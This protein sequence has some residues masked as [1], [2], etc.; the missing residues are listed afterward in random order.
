MVSLSSFRPCQLLSRSLYDK[1]VS[2]STCSDVC[3]CILPQVCNGDTGHTE[4]VQF[5]ASVRPLLGA[6]RRQPLPPESG[7]PR[8]HGHFYPPLRVKYLDFQEVHSCA[9]KTT[10]ATNATQKQWSGNSQKLVC[11]RV[12]VRARALSTGRGW[13][14][15]WTSAEGER[16]GMRTFTHVSGQ[17]FGARSRG[18]AMTAFMITP[19]KTAAT[20]LS[21]QRRASF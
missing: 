20:S 7:K 15:R 1:L 14:L 10:N 12:C 4:A 8:R 9:Q 11:L 6:S 17:R 13:A 21:E 3:A 16:F 19:R 5:R 2:G 18:D